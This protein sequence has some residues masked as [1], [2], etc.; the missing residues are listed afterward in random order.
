MNQAPSQSS[1]ADKLRSALCDR[2]AQQLIQPLSEI[3]DEM[4]SQEARFADLLG[5]IQQHYAESALNLLHYLVLRRHDL[6]EF[7]PRLARLGL[8]SLGRSEAHVGFSL[9]AVLRALHAMAA[10]P[11]PPELEGLVGYDDGSHRL[12]HNA[13][14]LLGKCS[15]ARAT[16]IMVTIPAQA[17]TDFDLVRDLVMSGMNVMRI[18]CA[19][20]GPEAWAGMRANLIRACRETGLNCRIQ[21]DLSGPKLRTGAMQPG[22]G[23][24]KLS[25]RRDMRGSVL[26][27]ARLLLVSERPEGELP[28]PDAVL[29]FPAGVLR[30]LK[31]NDR[32]NLRD[33]RGSSRELQC[34]SSGRGWSLLETTKTCYLGDGVKFELPDGRKHIL[35]SVPHEPGE[36]LLKPGDYIVLTADPAPGHVGE[37]VIDGKASPVA[38]VPCT[39]PEVLGQ[40]KTGEPVWLDDGKIGAVVIDASA[41]ELILKITHAR[42]Q[43]SRLSADKGINFPDS[44][45]EL[46]SLTDKDRED[47]KFV[48][49]NA[50]IVGMSFVNRPQDVRDLQREM[51][52][53]SAGGLA[54]VLKIET[55]R[56]FDN[57]PAILLAAMASYPVGVMIARGDLAVECGFERMAEVQE[58]ILWICEA[59]HLP[60]IW[61]TQVLETLAKKGAPTRA[62]VTDAAMGER[63]EC[64]MLNKGPHI[65]KA[66][67]MLDDIL[68]R[69][70]SHQQKKSPLLRMLHVAERNFD[71]EFDS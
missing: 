63:A 37:R 11:Q 1:Q 17:A 12:K 45:L 53:L 47:L 20:D 66:V 6:N 62:E 34:V 22:E 49:R 40:V 46:A 44:N 60:V 69:M 5:T 55:R 24:V 27:N 35:D 43:G 56:A 14:S 3:F 8:S 58:E 18:N 15:P 71:G 65:T 23:V 25:P 50:D 33:L 41:D 30:K 26:S 9:Q 38:T 39:L 68:R 28:A 48:A 67:A 32:L 31:K 13:D 59:A 29:R 70:Q 64:V 54:V 51:K 36:F 16:R 10:L 21:M 52:A 7:Q 42:E 4:L 57:L 19:H 61:A 2:Q